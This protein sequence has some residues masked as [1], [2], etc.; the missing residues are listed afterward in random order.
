M[1]TMSK[2]RHLGEE[3]RENLNQM[4]IRVTGMLRDGSEASCDPLSNQ[5]T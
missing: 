1:E 2:N 4:L 5:G 3:L